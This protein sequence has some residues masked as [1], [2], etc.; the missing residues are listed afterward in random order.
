MHDSPLPFATVIGRRGFIKGGVSGLLL[1]IAGARLTTGCAGSAPGWRLLLSDRALCG[2]CRRCAIT[3]SSLRADAPAGT[4]GLSD[5]DM[6]YQ[7]VA[8]ESAYWFANTCHNC[9]E[10]R[11]GNVL[12][13]PMCVAVCPTG[14]C[15]I[16]APGDP[17]Y[18]EVDV[19]FIDQDTCVGC[20]AC[21]RFCPHSH[22]LV[23]D[24]KSHKCDLCIGRA[25]S[26]PCVQACPAG[27][28]QCLDYWTET[29]PRPF[30]WDAGGDPAASSNGG[31]SEG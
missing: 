8:F 27:S 29:S 23:F 17:R 31:T 10:V 26:P 25:E 13:A 12:E 4:H 9:P 19:R 2:A 22:P 6:H 5:P 20:G 7:A 16:S 28:L 30:P 15:Q 1:V 21:A 14:A 18:G 3:C 11:Q 24:N